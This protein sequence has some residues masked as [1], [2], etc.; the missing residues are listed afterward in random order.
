MSQLDEFFYIELAEACDGDKSKILAVAAEALT[1]VNGHTEA[2]IVRQLLEK[3]NW[4]NAQVDALF[5]TAFG[6]GASP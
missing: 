3:S 2:A 1:H 4:E 5:D 6:Y